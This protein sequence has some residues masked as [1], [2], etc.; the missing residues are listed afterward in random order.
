MGKNKKQQIL[1]TALKLFA[2]QGYDETTTVQISKEAG[3]TEPLL[4]YHFKNKEEIF[5]HILKAIF[6]EYKEMISRLPQNTNCEFERIE[7]LIRLHFNIAEVRPLEGRLILAHCPAKLKENNHFCAKII[8]EQ[9]E[10]LLNYLCD[11][12]QKG[13]S[14]KEFK[15]VPVIETS[16]VLL[17][18]INGLFR[19]KLFEAEE[20]HAYEEVAISFCRN[21][22]LNT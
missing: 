18:F 7:N 3:V 8:E 2:L 1:N 13:I 9:K 14:K 10:L 12:L 4:Y 19:K 22:L 16:L 15:K 6:S 20:N 11:C 17:C 21:S 5:T